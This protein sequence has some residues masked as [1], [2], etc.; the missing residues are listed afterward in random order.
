[1][2]S[3]AEPEA[4]W[5]RLKALGYQEQKNID[6]TRLMATKLELNQGS[7]MGTLALVLQMV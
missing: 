6:M 7:F 1:M 3:Q 5:H 4:A 2:K